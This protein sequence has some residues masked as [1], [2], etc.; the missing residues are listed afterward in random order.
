[1][2]IRVRVTRLEIE[3]ETNYDDPTFPK[4]DMTKVHLLSAP[5]GLATRVQ[6]TIV[7]PFGAPMPFSLGDLCV[8]TI[9]HAASL[10][11]ILSIDEDGVVTRDNAVGLGVVREVR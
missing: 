10:A 1:M 3:A 4:H 5:D 8:L 2:N 7:I 11:P 9:E 6:A